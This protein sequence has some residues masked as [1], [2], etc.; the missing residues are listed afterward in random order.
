MSQQIPSVPLI[1]NLDAWEAERARL[2]RARR[3]SICALSAVGLGV[4]I[5]H[6]VPESGLKTIA[7]TICS[8]A[9]L[10]FAANARR[11]A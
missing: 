1:V 4:Y 11:H 5:H 2:A 10:A 9:A 3:S 8:L 7:V 6:I